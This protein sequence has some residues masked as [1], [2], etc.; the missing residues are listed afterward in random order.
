VTQTMH[1]IRVQQFGDVNVLRLEVLPQP[2]PADD[3]MLVRVLAAGVGPW[4]AWV[5]E[6]RSAMQQALPLTP[7]ADVAGIVERT[8]AKVSSFRAGESAT[9]A[10]WPCSWRLGVR[11]K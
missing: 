8:G 7:G 1:A 2:V 9:S 5:R 4:D 3:E 6:G 11:A 10:R